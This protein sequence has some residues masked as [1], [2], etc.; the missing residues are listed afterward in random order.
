MCDC[1]RGQATWGV[2][3]RGR[4]KSLKNGSLRISLLTNKST[5]T[6]TDAS[7]GLHM[8]ESQNDSDRGFLWQRAGLGYDANDLSLKLEGFRPGACG[9]GSCLVPVT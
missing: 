8:P 5:P 3:N 9:H 7:P 6:V 2:S 4:G 1:A